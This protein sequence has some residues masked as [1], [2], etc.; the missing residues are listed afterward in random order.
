[1][2]LFK[3][4][5][6]R[7]HEAL[8]RVPTGVQ[9]FALNPRQ[10]KYLLCWQL[11]VFVSVAHRL[12]VC[13]SITEIIGPQESCVPLGSCSYVHRYQLVQIVYIEEKLN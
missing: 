9:S 8:G 10:L 1:M 13:I 6:N 3:N 4:S 7:C 5:E 2:V 12:S 11:F